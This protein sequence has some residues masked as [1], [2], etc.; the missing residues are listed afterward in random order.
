MTVGKVG[1]VELFYEESGSG[2][3]LVLVHGSWGDH[4]NWAA[5]VPLLAKT[6]RVVTYDRRGHSQ[7]SQPPGQGSVTQDVEDLAGLIELLDLGPA[8]VAG[9]S[10][11]ALITLRLAIA[12][13][14]LIRGFAAH[15]PPGIGLLADDP[16]Y[17]SMLQGFGS[18]IGAVAA[19]LEGRR[20]AE[21]A[22]LFVETIALGP[23]S[24]KMLPVEHQATFVRNAPTYLDEIRDHEALDIDLQ[25]LQTYAGPALL[26]QGDQS[27]PM[28]VP[29]LDRVQAVLPQ[30]ERRT[31]IGAGHVPHT[32]HPMEYATTL[33][34]FVEG[35]DGRP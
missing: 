33:T 9:N 18:R 21:A 30:S 20:D 3:S 32:T 12:H 23:G 11:G 15:E 28:F 34:E 4:N 26:T 25:Q 17:A 14:D 35:A 16:E 31:Y 10:F 5:V 27:P 1:D 22:E 6:F 19:M 7:S 13:P 8:F 2:P 29:V 24:W